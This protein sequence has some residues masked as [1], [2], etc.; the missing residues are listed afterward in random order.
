MKI[1]TLVIFALICVAL[2]PITRTHAAKQSEHLLGPTGL[3]GSI[4]GNSI[5][6]SDVA[7]GSP[8]HQKIKKGDVIVGIGGQKFTGDIRK[9]F[10]AAINAAETQEAGGKL[11]L[12]LSGGKTVELQLEVLGAYGKIAPY[13]CA[14]TDL[15]VKRGAEYLANEINE[16][17][18]N[19]GSYNSGPTH[20]ALLGLMAT[21]EREYINL[22][23][24]AI[25][26]SDILKPDEKVIEEQLAGERSMGPVGWQWGY[27]CILL[28]EYYLLTGDRSVLPALKTYA[29]SLARGQDAGGL[30]GHRMAVAGRLPGYAQMNQSSLSSFLGLL[31]ARKCGIDDP[32][33]NQG[34][35]KT[36]AYYATYIGRGGFNYGVHGPDIKRF[37]NNGMS[38]LAAMC[39]ALANNQEGVRFFSGL[40]ATAY[41]NLEQGHASNF[42]NPLWTP[43]GASLSGPEVTHRFFMESQWYFTNY[44]AWDG[45]FLRSPGRERR[46]SGSQT[47]LALLTYC[48]PRKVL[49]ITGR[50]QDPSLWLPGDA[51]TE[52]LQMS[53]IDYPSKSVDELLALFESPFPQV[54]IKAVWTLRDRSPEFLPQVV[55][56][57]E[58]GTPRQR[59]SALQYFGYQC[60]PEQAHPQIGRVGAILRNQHEDPELRAQAAAMLASHGEAAYDYYND[61]LQLV[62]DD[63]PGDHFQD[64]D[65]SVGKSLNT[66]CS[67]PYA[68]GLVKDKPLFYAAA[69]KLIEHKRQHARSAGI[70]ML[71]EI[72]REDFPLMAESIVNI[73]EDQDNTY[74]SYHSWQSTIGPAIEIL[75]HLRIKEGLDYAAGIFDREG[76]KWGFKV[77]MFCASL[78]NYGANAKEVLAKVQTDKR[79]AN[80]EDGRFRGMWQ[81]MVKAIEE[82]PSPDELIT[83]QEALGYRR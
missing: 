17:L 77:R 45:S 16:S 69:Q 29:V 47:G 71:A 27:H 68:A 22:V 56:L 79:L 43:L 13:Q 81:K 14:K 15:I 66:L 50:E 62:V 11:P 1:Q 72:P 48:L 57:L 20:T 59:E 51:A 21:G 34:I 75:S 39:M 58:N 36:Y 64:V 44:R 65:Q 38:G 70:K 73:I 37:N 33:L 63:E 61:M 82:D 25:Q 23:E 46:R 28:G 83:L 80:I 3:A 53:K 24:K 41:D 52:V 35:A 12:L 54:R 19:Q 6:V 76:G 31:M 55:R 4:S 10:A 49:F 74:H 7:E 30:W 5:Q 9:L 67:T 40:S 78:P 32:D 26:A 2:L 42:F 8:A 18:R 60:P